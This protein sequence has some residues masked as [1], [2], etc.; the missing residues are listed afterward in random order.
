MRTWDANERARTEAALRESEGR[1]RLIVESARDYAILT[2]DRVAWSRPAHG[3]PRRRRTLGR[4]S[5]RPHALGCALL[6]PALAHRETE[7]RG[8]VG[9]A[10]LR[11]PVR[12]VR[13]H[14]LDADLE[15]RGDLLVAVPARDEP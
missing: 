2:T 9:H 8:A 3:A 5:P 11:H 10:E 12:L 7:E 6:Q 4:A 15:G 13:L 1:Y 14:R